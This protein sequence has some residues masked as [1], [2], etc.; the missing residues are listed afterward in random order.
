M[1]GFLKYVALDEDDT[2]VMPETGYI[3]VGANGATATIQIDLS[4]AGSRFY[5]ITETIE[6]GFMK[7]IQ[8]EIP[9]DST[10]KATGSDVDLQVWGK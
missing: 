8:I 10:I 4:G 7:G 6:D 1:V 3:N 9:K 5:N 2:Y